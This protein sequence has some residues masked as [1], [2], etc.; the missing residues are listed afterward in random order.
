[1]PG[2]EHTEQLKSGKTKRIYLQTGAAA[3]QALTDAEAKGRLP[4]LGPRRLGIG[5]RASEAWRDGGA[6][7]ASR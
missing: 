4:G 6:G 5:A 3:A 7:S 2:F 1:M